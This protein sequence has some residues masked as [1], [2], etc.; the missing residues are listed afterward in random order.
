MLNVGRSTIREG[1]KALTSRNVLEIRRGAGTFISQKGGIADDPLG[2]AFVKDKL[3]LVTDLLEVRFMIEPEIACIAA[4]KATDQ[5]IDKLAKLCDEVEELIINRKEHGSKDIE[6]HAQIASS[7]KN[8][9]VANLVPII[10]Q[11]ITISIDVT[12]RKLEQETIDTH[13]EVVN[14]IKNHDPKAAHDA[15]YLHLVYNRRNTKKV[16]ENNGYLE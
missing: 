16:I 11:S 7:S 14:A 9:I 8:S 1:I 4:I 3:K 10:N 15:M 5:E 13:R 2:L 6:F 12:Q